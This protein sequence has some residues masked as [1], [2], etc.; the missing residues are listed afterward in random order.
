[1]STLMH[2]KYSANL[3]WELW[4]YVGGRVLNPRQTTDEALAKLKGGFVYTTIPVAKRGTML[5]ERLQRAGYHTIAVPF[6]ASLSNANVRG[7]APRTI[8][9]F[10]NESSLRLYPR[11]FDQ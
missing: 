5:A 10:E 8:G 11:E 3:R 2:A 4:P 1:M 9:R 6:A 7:H